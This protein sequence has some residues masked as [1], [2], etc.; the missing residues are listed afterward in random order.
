M[1]PTQGGRGVAYSLLG[2]IRREG[3]TDSPGTPIVLATGG[4]KGGAARTA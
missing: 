1:Q 4:G 2:C 3:G